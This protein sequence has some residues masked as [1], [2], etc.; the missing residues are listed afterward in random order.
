MIEGEL[1]QKK[2]INTKKL[3]GFVQNRVINKEFAMNLTYLSGEGC[4]RVC[5]IYKNLLR[6]I[7]IFFY[8]K[9]HQFLN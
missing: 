8:E 1:K 4:D 6:D 3:F 7:K 5:Y 9:F 2:I